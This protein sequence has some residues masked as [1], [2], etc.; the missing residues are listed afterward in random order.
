MLGI[1][2]NEY[3]LIIDVGKKKKLLDNNEELTEQAVNIIEQIR[4]K[5]KFQNENQ[6][7]NKLKIEEDIVYVPRKFRGSS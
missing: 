5:I 1:N 2:I 7:N 3:N 4:K 6:I